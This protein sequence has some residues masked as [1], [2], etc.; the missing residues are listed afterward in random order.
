MTKRIAV[1][2]SLMFTALVGGATLA[3]ATGPSF[4]SPRPGPQ[5]THYVPPAP[6][7]S[8]SPRPTAPRPT[9]PAPTFTQTRP[10]PRITHTAGACR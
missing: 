9:A 6:S 7:P 2:L 5:I 1:A 10:G 4:N 3:T 8:W